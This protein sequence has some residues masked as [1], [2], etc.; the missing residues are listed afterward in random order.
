M[1]SLVL[2]RVFFLAAASLMLCV[3]I[4]GA[5]SDTQAADAETPSPVYEH[6]ELTLMFPRHGETFVS[7]RFEPSIKVCFYLTASN[8]S[9]TN[10]PDSKHYT[11]TVNFSGVGVITP[12]TIDNKYWKFSQQCLNYTYT[13]PLV[14]LSVD[15]R[16]IPSLGDEGYVIASYNMALLVV[17]ESDMVL[18]SLVMPN[19]A[20]NK[21]VDDALVNQVDNKLDFIEIGTSDFD[22]CMILSEYA[23]HASYSHLYTCPPHVH[24][25]FR[26]L[27]AD[28][29]RYYLER[30]CIDP[31]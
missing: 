29:V 31:E 20:T 3:Q 12:F 8:R 6:H 11:L 21:I 28:P 5:A 1:R 4:L 19:S 13:Q 26:G 27:S 25:S 24:K 9:Y 14:P 30:K 15:V 7:R 17:G 18:P 16:Y 22:T 10:I 2:L 23:C